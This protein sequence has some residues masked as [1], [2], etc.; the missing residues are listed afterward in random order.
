MKIM[1]GRNNGDSVNN[2]SYLLFSIYLLINYVHSTQ[3]SPQQQPSQ[4]Q[5]I[6]RAKRGTTLINYNSWWI[7][8]EIKLDLYFL[9]IYLCIKYESNLTIFSEDIEWTP[10]FVYR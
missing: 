3:M 2:D 6:F 9:I 1:S 7:L 5:Q 10:L 4:I 8:P